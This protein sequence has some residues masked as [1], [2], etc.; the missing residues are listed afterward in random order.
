MLANHRGISRHCEIRLLLPE[1]PLPRRYT[2]WRKAACEQFHPG[3]CGQPTS[4]RVLLDARLRLMV[5]EQRASYPRATWRL[6]VHS[7]AAGATN[8]A[9]DDAILSSVID[10]ASLPTLRFYQWAP[11]CLSLG[12][13]QKL[14]EVDL[15]ACTAAG[16]DIVR[17][18]T[19]GRSILHADELTYSVSL[20]QTDPRAKG[21]IVEGYRRL[22]EGLLAGLHC[23]GLSAVQSAGQAE[24]GGRSTAVCF[25]SPSD[26]EITVAGRKLVGSAQWRIRGGVLQHGSLPLHGDLTRIVDYLA[27]T[28][29]ERRTQRRRLRMRALTLQDATG[30]RY[31][32]EDVA[33]AIAEGFAT[34]L[35]LDLVPGE[36]SVEERLLS[37][38]L[39]DTQY[40]HP[41]WTARL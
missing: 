19:G 26:Y 40:A 23:L 22:S 6:I 10:A 24:P 1:A 2:T 37:A 31:S 21:G 3:P 11:I 25:E 36:V 5:G 41:D 38:E 7:E 32:F 20:S 4:A 13:N 17:R 29:A 30:T 33:R 8:M 12:R 34:A 16:V 39:R 15:P 27:F 28:N 35:N 18:P 9:V 14:A